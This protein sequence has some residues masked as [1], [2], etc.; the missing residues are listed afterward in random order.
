MRQVSRFFLALVF[1]LSASEAFAATVY[2]REAAAGTGSG[3]DWTNAR[4]TMPTLVRGDTIYIADGNY[5]GLTVSTAAS[6]TTTIVFRKA[7]A[8]DHG[9]ETGWDATYGDG[10]ATVASLLVEAKYLDFYRISVSGTVRVTPG[11]GNNPNLVA[12]INF[13]DIHFTSFY[14][15]AQDVLISGGEIGNRDPCVVGP[16]DLVQV[17]DN[18]VNASSSRVTFDGVAIHDSTDHG[19]SCAGTAVAGIHCDCLQLLGGHDITIKNSIFYNCPTSD[20]LGESYRDTLDGLLIE[21]NWFQNIQHPGVAI[22]FGALISGTNVIRYNTIFGSVATGATGGTINVYGNIL[23]VTNC[24][25]GVFSYN[26]FVGGTQCGTSTRT[27][28]P[29]VVYSPAPLYQNGNIPDYHLTSADT[30]AKDLGNAALYPTLDYDLGA[31]FVGSAPDLG[32]DEY[33]IGGPGV[34]AT[35]RGGTRGRLRR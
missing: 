17:W 6:G 12:F 21:N 30:A 31:R 19:D 13:Y 29:S 27:G 16:E 14:V 20:I 2:V 28:T 10:T 5:A 1:I 11:S 8:A 9:T 32:A 18:G 24:G 26:L 7:T 23:T 15:V 34:E 4:T 3:A 22:N 35:P 25:H 33:G